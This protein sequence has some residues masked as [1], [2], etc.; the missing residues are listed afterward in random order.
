MSPAQ[1]NFHSHACSLHSSHFPLLTGSG[2]VKATIYPDFKLCIYVCVFILY[3]HLCHFLICL[4]FR[5]SHGLQ[6]PIRTSHIMYGHPKSGFCCPVRKAVRGRR[7]FLIMPMEIA[8]SWETR[9]P[10]SPNFSPSN[11]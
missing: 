9:N 7:V 4:P 11:Q 2:C 5:L 3:A 8:P 10:T 1:A 6:Q